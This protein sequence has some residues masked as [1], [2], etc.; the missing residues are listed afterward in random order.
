MKRSLLLAIAGLAASGCYTSPSVSYSF[1]P[2]PESGV[3]YVVVTYAGGQVVDPTLPTIGCLYNGV[4]GATF[5]SQPAGAI[6][7]RVTAY[8][9]VQGLG[10]VATY[11]AQQSVPVAIPGSSVVLY[12][13][14]DR[15][16]AAGNIATTYD[17][18]VGTCGVPPCAD[19]H[20]AGIPD[21]F[22]IYA[23]FVNAGGTATI[24]TY[25]AAPSVA[26][27]SLTYTLVDH[28]G[29][30][31]AGGSMDCGA[32]GPPIAPA[33]VSFRLAGTGG[34][35]LDD[36]AIRIQGFVTGTIDPIFDTATKAPVPLYPN[37]IG[38][39][40]PHFGSDTGSL[41]WDTRVFDVSTNT[42]LCP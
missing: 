13:D 24:G 8:Q 23:N 19:V 5:L 32:A 3:D 37:C 17:A 34:I 4:Q 38:Q 40:F 30:E 14:F 26:I 28:F 9:N 16:D 22:D 41:A 42:L 35:D 31:V 25:C 20:L 36:Y 10:P 15:Y 39:T 29:T 6:T 11:E 2:C 21:D 12:W 33:G 18:L 7:Y 1:A 27:D